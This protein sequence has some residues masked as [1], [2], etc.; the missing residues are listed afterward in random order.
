MGRTNTRL[1]VLEQ[2]IKVDD[3]L[4]GLTSGDFN[5]VKI[6]KGTKGWI[7]GDIHLAQVWVWDG[8]EEQPRERT[9][10]IR[11]GLKKGD[12]I[13]YCLSNVP[14]SKRTDQQF[15]FMQAQRHWVERAFEDGK[16]ELGMADYQVRKYNA[17]Y[18]HQALVML[19]MQF[20]NR[21]KIELKQDIPLISVRDVRLQLIATLK[22]QGTQMEKEID[23]MLLRHQQRLKD[24]N[25]YYPDNEHF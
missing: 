5:R 22:E 15:A 16:G 23:Q 8:K 7:M 6:R 4:L 12:P 3:Y 14:V 21:K 24:I 19:A 1:K 25:R 17:W 20:V 13:K 2:S 11:K 9:L 10:M 18:H